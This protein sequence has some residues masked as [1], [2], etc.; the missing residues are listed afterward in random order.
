MD[1]AAG[2][3]VGSSMDAVS[4]GVSDVAVEGAATMGASAAISSTL[5]EA[6]A[7]G[8]AEESSLGR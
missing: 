5:G 1:W 4:A 8:A 3:A 6:C 7:T 2:A